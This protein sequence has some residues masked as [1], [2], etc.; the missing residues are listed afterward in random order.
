MEWG[1]GAR[2][3]AGIAANMKWKIAG[4]IWVRVVG[5]G[6]ILFDVYSFWPGHTGCGIVGACTISRVIARMCEGRVGRHFSD[7]HIAEEIRILGRL[8]VFGCLSD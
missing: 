2:R 5:R 1:G 8:G 6:D 7:D 3:K 4:H